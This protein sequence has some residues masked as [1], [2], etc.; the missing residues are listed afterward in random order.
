MT[1]RSIK[2]RPLLSCTYVENETEGEQGRK[3]KLV[4]LARVS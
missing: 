1:T 2:G 3:K 4:V